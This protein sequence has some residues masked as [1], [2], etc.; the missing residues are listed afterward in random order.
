MAHIRIDHELGPGSSVARKITC[1]A[2]NGTKNPSTTLYGFDRLSVVY[3]S[4]VLVD[5][6]PVTD[7]NLLS[8]AI[9]GTSDP[10][11]CMAGR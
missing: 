3:L 10:D 1:K 7:R 9:R 11:S 4:I 6:D 8:S 5:P 2:K